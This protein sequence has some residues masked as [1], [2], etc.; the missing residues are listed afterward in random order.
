MTGTGSV[1]FAV[2]SLPARTVS[3]LVFA[4]Y[5]LL[6]ALSVIAY[7]YQ[8]NPDGV[9]HMS[10]AQKYAAGTAP[11]RSTRTG[12]RSI[13]GCSRRC[14]GPACR[15]CW[16]RRILS[17]AIGLTTVFILQRLATRLRH[18][19]R[20]NSYGCPHRLRRKP[21]RCGLHR[22]PDGPVLLWSAGSRLN[23]RAS[24]MLDTRFRRDLFLAMGRHESMQF[25]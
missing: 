23:P 22:I 3:W 2:R 9:S 25:R 17:A 19:G 5:T 20:R 12:A 7:R 16:R 6:A 4:A 13:A 8:L 15:R 10:I 11:M 1:T 14:C 24:R 18:T 21:G